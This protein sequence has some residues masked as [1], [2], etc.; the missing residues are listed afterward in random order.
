MD[1]GLKDI[2]FFEHDSASFKFPRSFN[3]LPR[4]KC[5]TANSE[6]ISIALRVYSSAS[7]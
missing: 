3:I 2:I 7:F 1:Q 4:F 5:A 6:L